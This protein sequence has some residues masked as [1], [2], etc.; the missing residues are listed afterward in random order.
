MRDLRA[1]RKSCD[2]KRQRKPRTVWRSPYRFDGVATP[3]KLPI[4]LIRPWRVRLN[5]LVDLFFSIRVGTTARSSS[6]SWNAANV[7]LIA[8]MLT[9]SGDH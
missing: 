8:F 5:T 3:A 1:Q 6:F 7:L 2:P 4:L 9:V